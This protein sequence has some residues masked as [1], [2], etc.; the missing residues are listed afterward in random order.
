M[1]LYTVHVSDFWSSPLATVQPVLRSVF[2]TTVA[3]YPKNAAKPAAEP[4]PGHK[5]RSPAHTMVNSAN[6]G[7]PGSSS[8]PKL[9]KKACRSATLPKILSKAER[10]QEFADTSGTFRSGSEGTLCSEGLSLSETLPKNPSSSSLTNHCRA[11]SAFQTPPIRTLDG[12]D[13]NPAK[14][15]NGYLVDV[16]PPGTPPSVFRPIRRD[17]GLTAKQMTL[18]VSTN[19]QQL[20]SHNLGYVSDCA[21][22]GD[23]IDP[24]FVVD[25][26]STPSERNKAIDRV[27]ESKTALTQHV[28]VPQKK[29]LVKKFDP[30]V[31]TFD[32][33][34]PKTEVEPANKSPRTVIS[35]VTY[36]IGQHTPTLST[37][38]SQYS[39][40]AYAEP[41][42]SLIGKVKGVS[43]VSGAIKVNNI[44]KQQRL[45]Q[46]ENEVPSV[47]KLSDPPKRTPSNKLGRHRHEVSP[48][49]HGHP[50][51]VHGPILDKPPP[52]PFKVG[53]VTVNIVRSGHRDSHSGSTS[54]GDS[55]VRTPTYGRSQS[56]R[57]L[58]PPL[59]HH[60]SAR[61]RDHPRAKSLPKEVSD[62]KGSKG[63]HSKREPRSQPQVLP[64][65]PAAP[66]SPPVYSPVL[67]Q[68]IEDDLRAV[69]ESLEETPCMQTT[70][71]PVYRGDNP[72][73]NRTSYSETTTVEDLISNESPE[74]TLKPIRPLTI[75][76]LQRMSDYDN[77]HQRGPGSRRTVASSA[78]THYCQPWDSTPWQDLMQ[79]THL[80]RQ[81]KLSDNTPPIAQS[82]PNVYRDAQTKVPD[83]KTRPLSEADY[84]SVYYGSESGRPNSDFFGSDVAMP[85]SCSPDHGP[86]AVS[87]LTTRLCEEQIVRNGVAVSDDEGVDD[88]QEADR[89]GPLGKLGIK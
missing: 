48:P 44:L 86:V 70:R 20:S 89:N 81:P 58:T 18:A 26:K 40:P 65:D 69:L 11:R 75:R 22:E 63:L 41:Y 12:P 10:G 24:D 55:H 46:L 43:Q 87:V 47:P 64:S 2:H 77:L 13:L 79:A 15:N 61:P 73:S 50:T 35:K 52:S 8:P 21:S 84:S 32:L 28:I 54:S 37:C 1:L 83:P 80:P 62:L 59:E 3:A 76:N 88:D 23:F 17:Q 71:F 74:L 5:R 27:L 14:L 78:G 38:G 31:F 66:A 6:T 82:S 25:V 39:S 9:G 42:D 19:K 49:R 7:S 60:H 16:P 34:V 30:V 51:T 45:E 33:K 57:S 36:Q 29:T 72:C 56:L 68:E 67:P 4:H 53:N 85:M